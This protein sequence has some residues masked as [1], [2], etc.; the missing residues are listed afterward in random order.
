MPANRYF[1]DADFKVGNR[2]ELA[3]HEQHH[4]ANVMRNHVGDRVELV[5][6]RG[7][8]ANASVMM[9]GRREAVLEVKDVIQHP[10]PKSTVILAQAIPRANRLDFILEKGTELGMSE[11]W[12][13]PAERS[14][15]G[16]FSETQLERMQHVTIAAMKQCGR[17]YLPRIVIRDHFSKWEKFEG[18]VC[19]GDLECRKGDIAALK[20]KVRILFVVGPESGF[21]ESEVVFLRTTGAKGLK[22][23]DNVLRAETA[24]LSGLS[25]IHFHIDN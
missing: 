18:V 11:L 22:L 3:G 6:G 9:V 20:N 7:G 17:F 19:F 24:A 10:P 23:N 4:L 16:K 5:N 14:E 12:L 2:L 13:F 1:I 25:I 8:F 21:S 15:R